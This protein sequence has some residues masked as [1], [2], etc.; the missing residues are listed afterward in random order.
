MKRKLVRF[1]KEARGVPTAISYVCGGITNKPPLKGELRMDLYD[2][3][4]S[5][6]LYTFFK[7]LTIEGYRVVLRARPATLYSIKHS[8]YGA[9]LLEQR[10]LKLTLC[11]G[12]GFILG[13]R[14]GG[15]RLIPWDFY[16]KESSMPDRSVYRVP[17]AQH[18]MM[19]ASGCWSQPVESIKAPA[20]SVLFV[21]NPDPGVYSK[22]SSDRVFDVVDRVKLWNLLKKRSEAFEV[23]AI[24]R[25]SADPSGRI[26]LIDSRSVHL[27]FDSFRS[28][29]R[30][31]RF[32]LCAPG[33]FMPLCHNL[34]E[35]LSVGVVPVIQKSYSDLLCPPLCDGVNAIIFNGEHDLHQAM[36]RCLEMG[37]EMIERLSRGAW[38][39]YE[40][41]L[42]PS[43]V[44]RSVLNP[45]V[46]TVQLLAGEH[47]VNLLR[48]YRSTR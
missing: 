47:S 15:K 4:Y 7:F 32:F 27:P 25:I 31:F 8:Q 6:Y 24:A 41:H 48:Q 29:L 14:I 3:I 20:N 23:D 34:V 44:T 22:I 17:M 10:L 12:A 21:G 18:P 30:D 26:V 11:E 5:R 38:S 1:L 2:N 37:E 45:M 46:Q 19:Y 35:A 39:Y 16:R 42:T 40:N 36:N 13:D 28:V 33:V 9:L 43:A